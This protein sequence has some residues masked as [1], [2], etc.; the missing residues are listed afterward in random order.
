MNPSTS[1][2]FDRITGAFGPAL[3]VPSF[4]KWF[5]R[6]MLAAPTAI[7][8]L[9]A[10]QGLVSPAR[11][12]AARGIAL[13]SALGVTTARIG[14]G[15]FPLAIAFVLFCCLLSTRR[16]LAG[17]YF[18]VTLDAVVLVVRAIA[19]VIDGPAAESVRLFIPEAMIFVLGLVAVY[20]QRRNRARLRMPS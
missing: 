5:T 12:M 16:H 2:D 8:S 18:L 19:T 6:F 4:T 9:I 11:E 10:R 17:L 15:A 3:D 14:F 1:S 13:E 20:L 7:F